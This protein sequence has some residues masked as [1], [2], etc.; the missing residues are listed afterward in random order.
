MSPAQTFLHCFAAVTGLGCALAAC[1]FLFFGLR[2]L[3][4]ALA[5]AADAHERN[6]PR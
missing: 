1:A 6:H 3:L 5:K 2:G 4:E